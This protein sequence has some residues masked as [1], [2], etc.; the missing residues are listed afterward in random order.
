MTYQDDS[1][2]PLL[3]LTLVF[4]LNIGAMALSI[5]GNESLDTAI[6]SA[7]AFWFLSHQKH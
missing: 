6:L 7:G 5:P 2:I 4:T 1:F 3:L